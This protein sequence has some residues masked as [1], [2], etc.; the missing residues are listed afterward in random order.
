MTGTGEGKR[1][2]LRHELDL[3]RGRIDYAVEL[4]YQDP[5]DLDAMAAHAGLTLQTALEQLA[6]R[7]P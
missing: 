4:L 3:P 6:R 1:V 5:D 7:A 2:S